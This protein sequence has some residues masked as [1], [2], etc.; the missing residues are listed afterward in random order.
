MNGSSGAFEQL[1]DLVFPTYCFGCRKGGGRVLC[2][3]CLAR[4]ASSCYP[5]EPDPPGDCP[6]HYPG[7]KGFRAAGLYHGVIKE[8]VLGLKSHGRPFA[9]PLARL[10]IAAAGNDPDYIA[11][12]AICYVPSERIK[13]RK[14]GHNPAEVLACAVSTLL[15][16]PVIHHLEKTKATKDQD[17]LPAALRLSNVSGA[18]SC[19]NG[20]RAYGSVLLIDDVLTTGATA[21]ACA[22]ALLDAGADAV[23]AL[24]A[25]RAA[26][27]SEHV[28][29]EER[30][31][32][33]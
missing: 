15:D 28:S 29:L 12:D 16:R 5:A 20:F 18:F 26:L 30:T 6:G 11:P 27:R 10:M 31:A 23:N 19:I 25:A 13:V 33:P 21:Q 17:Q 32:R 9:F 3:S 4:I 7:L 2:E 24:V 22:A 14:R 1:L 8:L